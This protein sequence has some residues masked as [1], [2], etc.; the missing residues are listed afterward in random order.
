MGLLE[1]KM[2]SGCFGLLIYVNE[3]S[4]VASK[5]KAIVA[6]NVKLMYLC[7]DFVTNCL[8]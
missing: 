6:Y 1:A 7:T 3:I 4:V 2:L 5:S 8:L